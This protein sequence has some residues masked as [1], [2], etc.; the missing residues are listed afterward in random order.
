MLP[1][2]DS[3]LLVKAAN[4]VASENGFTKADVIGKT[5]YLYLNDCF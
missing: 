1:N 2:F 3:D 4:K 5:I